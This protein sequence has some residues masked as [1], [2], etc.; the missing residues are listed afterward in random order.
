MNYTFPT[1]IPAQHQNSM[2]GIES[3]MNPNP[4]YEI[5]GYHKPSGRL[6]DKITVI[7]GGDSGI[8][9]A[10]SIL[11]AKE[12]AKVCIIYLN[13]HEDANKTKEI[14]ESYGGECTL[15]A[16][17]IGDET[18]CKT[19]ITN[20]ISKYKNINI[21]VSNAA[22]QHDCKTINEIT[23][24]QLHN[25]FNTNF[26]GAFY[27]TQEIVPHMKSGDS[28]IYTTSVTAY[29]GHETLI[30]YSCTKGALTTLTRS[31]A[32][33]LAPQGIRVNSVAPGPIWTPLIPSSFNE[34]KVSQFGKQTL[35]KRPGQPVEV[36]ESYVF[37]ASDG[38]SFI[39][40][41]TIH[42]NGGEIVNN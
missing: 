13:E 30:D 1:T 4:V 36:A 12:G 33:N 7:T 10:V 9:R 22:E 32:K 18:F 24:S 29:H 5:E 28:I 14:I 8:G 35:F 26:F 15:Y 38:A 39:T 6:Q 19:T 31:L 2:P 17:N 27:L 25:T 20:I 21:F 3:Q 11:Y 42:V 40:G 37:L 34:Y 41:E 23:T 16:G